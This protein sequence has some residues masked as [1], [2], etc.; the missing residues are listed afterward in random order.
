MATKTYAAGDPEVVKLWSKR[1]A[2]EALKQTVI[3]PYIRDDGNA[4]CE[5]KMDTQKGPGDRITCTLRMQL[6]GD[7]V[8][9]TETQEGNEEAITTYTDNLYINE[10]SHAF[11]GKAKITQQ[12]VPFDMAREG[13]DAL[14]DWWAG[15]IDT[16][17]FNHLCGYTPANS[18][19]GGTGKYT[20]FNT[21]TAP[22]SGRHLWTLSGATTDEDLT[23]TNVFTLEMIDKAKEVAKTG[24]TAG[25]V[26]IRPIRGLPGGAKYVCFLHPSQVT[27]LRTSTDTNGWMDIQKA[28]LSGGEG[29]SSK[30]FQ[31]GLGVWNETLLVEADRVTYGVNSTTGEA[32]T[33]TRRA[34]FCG[35]QSL[36]TAYGKG[37]GPEK[38]QSQEETFDF[39][40]QYA[41][42][43]LNLF[44]FKKAVYNSSDFAAMVISSYAQHA[45]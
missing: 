44:G 36:I 1:L 20:G 30:I 33:T 9:E 34:V 10:L 40:R 27:S 37:Y 42:N 6:N 18:M 22:T 17:A 16:C 25:L 23:S 11:R 4:L 35:A 5:L 7:G 45:A 3:F 13:N 26:P 15:R 19:G 28:L 24:G 14:S 39:G 2:R 43:G 8:D 38:W 12:R 31:D 29:K 32:I 41:A 21:V